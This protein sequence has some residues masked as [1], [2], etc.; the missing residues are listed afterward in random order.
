MK[1]LISVALE[2]SKNDFNRL[3]AGV[4]ELKIN[5]TE[6]IRQAVSEK[7]FG[8]SEAGILGTCHNMF[9]ED[10]WGKNK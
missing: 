6:F 9:N 3:N 2:I 1:R 8:L 5:R 4:T 7:L 10:D